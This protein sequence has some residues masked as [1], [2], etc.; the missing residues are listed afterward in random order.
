MFAGLLDKDFDAY[1]PAKWRS[2]VFNRERLDVKQKLLDLGRALAGGMVAADDSPLLLEASAEH[3]A[4]WNHKQVEGQHLYFSRH[5]AARKEIDGII[6][7]SRPMSTMLE[8]P[9]PQRNHVYLGVSMNHEG[10][11]VALKLHPDAHV[12]RQNLER[13]LDEAWEREK[14]LDLVHALPDG[15]SVG[16]LAGGHGPSAELD[17]DKLNGL[18]A[19]LARPEAPGKTHWFAFTRAVPRADAVA[20]GA[21]LVERVREQLA[22]LLPVYH[23]IAWSRDNDYVLMKEQIKQEKV[24]KRQKGLS[25]NDKVKIVRGMF[26]GRTGVVQEIDAKGALKVLVGTVAVKVA[27]DEVEKT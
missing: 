23:F 17:N 15:T 21:D 27:A 16:V 18:L 10:I 19:D 24:V 12:D 3:P 9:T 6:D 8:D 1:L 22:A 25:K 5:A 13:K 4:L 14:F 20:A 26:S 11:E 7:R 2:N